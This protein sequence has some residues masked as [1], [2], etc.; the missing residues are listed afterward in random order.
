MARGLSALNETRPPSVKRKPRSAATL[1]R[2]P[3]TQDPLCS[4]RITWQSQDGRAAAWSLDRRSGGPLTARP[5]APARR[6]DPWD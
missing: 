3:I 1:V 2:A 6:A 5:R 4:S